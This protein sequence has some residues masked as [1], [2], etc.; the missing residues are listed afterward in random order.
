MKKQL[1]FVITLFVIIAIIAVTLGACEK[2]D[3]DPP[4]SVPGDGEQAETIKV[5]FYVDGG[6][7]GIAVCVGNTMAMPKEPFKDG[8]SFVGW[9]YDEELT[10]SF[11][12]EEFLAD[13]NKTDVALY[14]AWNLTE[15]PSEG[16]ETGGETGE[17]GQ[18]GDEDEGE[19]QTPQE[20][21][22]SVF[23]VTF[24]MN[25]EILSVQQVEKGK[26]ATLPLSQ[27]RVD[28]NSLYSLSVNGKY[29][30]VEKDETVE[31]SW[32]EASDDEKGLFALGYLTLLV[33]KGKMYVSEIS[34]SYPFDYIVLPSSWGFFSI[35]GI[36]DGAFARVPQLTEITLLGSGF[37]EI[38]WQAF[39]DLILLDNL[40]FDEANPSYSSCGL[41]ITDSSG[42]QLLRYI[43]KEVE[44]VIPE[45]VNTIAEGAFCG[46]NYTSV[47]V[48]EVITEI[49]DRAFENCS[50]ITTLSLPATLKNIGE[51]AFENCVSLESLTV[52]EGVEYIGNRAFAGCV[53][54]TEVNYLASEAYAP[55]EGN[56][57][58]DNAGG[59]NGLRLYVGNKVKVIPARMFDA[60]S[61]SGPMLNEVKFDEEGILSEIGV[62]AFAGTALKS[63][64]IPSTVTTLSAGA[65]EG[66][67]AL[68]SVYY[69]AIDAATQ[70]IS[71]TAFSQAGSESSVFT[72]GKYVEKV[73]DYLLY[74]LGQSPSFT[75]LTF[76]QGSL[77][78]EIGKLAFAG[79]QFVGEVCLPATVTSLGDGA[80][81]QCLKLSA[82]TVEEGGAYV[83]EGGVVYTADG[84]TLEVYPAGKAGTEYAVK[85]SASEI[86]AYAFSYA[87]ML[88]KV[89]FSCARVGDA[90]FMSCVAIK[91]LCM[92][93]GV[94]EIGVAAF[95]QCSSL[96]SLACPSTLKK[97]E[98]NAFL[99]CDSLSEV[100]LN[101]GLLELGGYAFAYCPLLKEPALPDSLI[102]I[103][104]NVF[105][106]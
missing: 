44:I 66:C 77:C 13:E 64:N 99:N 88:E 103:G 27:F 26:N 61:E 70:G 55:V 31:L 19:E 98:D 96:L 23:K 67:V 86:S 41:F 87:Y 106:K 74:S 93:E 40:V 3:V 72:V 17:G 68:E 12:L 8:Y 59:G 38:E 58:F 25:G 21:E 102:D 37:T 46:G 69:G 39:D 10:R 75:T 51:S 80:F 82:I 32:K 35:S 62:R 94:E 85:E 5:S 57:I 89:T 29:T 56:A 90:A 20:P 48:P 42:K 30:E 83:S 7:Y 33:K 14:A 60:L 100:S 36:K 91:E 43:G 53:A 6:L 47:T 49:G 71:G 9:F 15:N 97:I 34:P 79:A 22:Q 76:E 105:A 84:S 16:G 101:D 4:D 45:Q 95:T 63:V 73:P 65:F 81:S 2:V 104:D 28:G 54:A 78:S 11:V 18:T 52:P 24:I 92:E 1:I 50:F